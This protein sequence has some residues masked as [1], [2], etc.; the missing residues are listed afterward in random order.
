MGIDNNDD[1]AKMFGVKSNTEKKENKNVINM[2]EIKINGDSGKGVEEKL[3]NVPPFILLGIVLIVAGTMSPYKFLY[4]LGFCCIIIAVFDKILGEEKKKL[5]FV[6]IK[7]LFNKKD[8]TKCPKCNGLLEYKD[9]PY[10]VKCCTSC[11]YI[12]KVKL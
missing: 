8:T 10:K 3:K 1:I 12:E 11:D 7:A 5:L 2:E 9:I 4:T 6:K